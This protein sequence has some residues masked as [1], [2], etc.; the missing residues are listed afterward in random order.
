[1][2]CS[3]PKKNKLDQKFD[4]LFDWLFVYQVR[5]LS[6]LRHPNLVK[7][8]GCCSEAFVLVYEYL[9]NGNLE[10]WLYCKNKSTPLSWQ[11]RIHVVS[12]LCSVLVYLHSRKPHSIVHGDLK[13]SNI[14]FSMPTLWVNLVTLE[15]AVYYAMKEDQATIQHCVILLINQRALPLT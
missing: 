9:P 2:F 7:L 3:L 15:S 12:E 14:S 10:D 13:P 1:M 4:F 11:T 6:Q 5:A 8:I